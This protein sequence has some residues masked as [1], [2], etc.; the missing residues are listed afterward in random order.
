MSIVV[1]SDAL[2]LETRSDVKRRAILNGAKSAFLRNG[3]GGTSMDAVAAKAG[4]SKM[5]VYRHFGSKEDLFAGV[6]TELCERIVEDNLEEML[7]QNPKQALR[8]FA[9]RMIDIVFAPETIELHRIVVSESRRFPKL[10]HFF[11]IS[12]PERCNA[13]LEA[14]LRR[15]LDDPQFKVHNPRRAAEMFLEHLRGYAHLRTLLRV[16]KT[17][18]RRELDERI[19]GAV[20][21]ILG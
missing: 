10:G 5:T 20:R 9:R 1:Q 15:N 21:H 11:Y 19:E 6:I 3:F 8:A 12:G 7:N 2:P 13:V 14:Y 17:P 16:E 4:V 18:S